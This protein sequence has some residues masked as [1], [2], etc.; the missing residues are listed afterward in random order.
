MLKL[1]RMTIMTRGNLENI[2]Q[3]NTHTNE[4]DKPKVI[5]KE[6]GIQRNQIRIWIDEDLENNKT[7]KPPDYSA[8]QNKSPLELFYLFFD[9]EICMHIISEIRKFALYKNCA[10]PDVSLDEL[11]CF[12]GIL[13][14]SGYHSRPSRRFYWDQESDMGVYMVKDATYEKK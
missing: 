8:F 9:N 3:E 10:D 4:K 7:F 2:G 6:K 13:I 11:K 1:M 12:F 5:M 14:L